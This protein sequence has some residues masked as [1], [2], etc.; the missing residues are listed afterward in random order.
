MKGY[1]ARASSFP[2][3]WE[4]PD[5]HIWKHTVKK[6]RESLSL[7]IRLHLAHINVKVKDYFARA[8]SLSP[9]WDTPD[10]HIWK[11][12]VK[13]GK[14]RKRES[15]NKDK[16]VRCKVTFGTYINVYKIYATLIGYI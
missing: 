3:L 8:S 11:H 1:F 7:D 5:R 4:I 2:P 10:R 9:R 14:R 13:K 6:K 15:L 12:T 16:N